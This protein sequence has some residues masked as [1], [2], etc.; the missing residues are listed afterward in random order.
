[1]IIALAPNLQKPQ[2]LALS[3]QIRDY[4]FARNIQ[5]V[6]TDACK[7]EL[8]LPALSSLT[9]PPDI[10]ISLGGDGSILSFIHAYPAIDAPILGINFGTL[11]FLADIPVAEATTALQ[12]VLSG[13]FSIQKRL[14]LAAKHEENAEWFAVNEVVFHRGRI[15][16]L[17][18]LSLSVDG[19][20]L[21]TF[22]ADGIIIATPSGST[23]YSL[24]A[25]GPIIA[26]DLEAICLTP[27]CP[28]TL[29]NRPIVLKPPKEISVNYLSDHPPVE[30]SF[31]GVFRTFLSTGQKFVIYP[32]RRSF[33][34]IELK[35]IDYFTVLRSKLGLTGTLKVD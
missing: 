11:G 32:A 23:A 12:E 18:D 33:S 26:P 27:I 35:G 5:V 28:H 24:S 17:I 9:M 7:D 29:S 14:M 34:L 3:C 21:N 15:P 19:K 20:Y 31:D 10:V 13:N 2:V 30:I 25:G 16:N 6:S 8:R 4:L 22:S 1:M